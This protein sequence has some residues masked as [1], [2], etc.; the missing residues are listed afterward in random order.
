MC[1]QQILY[2]II[3]T[4]KQIDD[5]VEKLSQAIINAMKKV[6]AEGLWSE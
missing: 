3:I 6:E 5:L 1:K 4:K 2:E